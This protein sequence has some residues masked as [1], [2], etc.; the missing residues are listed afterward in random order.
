M[1]AVHSSRGSLLSLTCDVAGQSMYDHPKTPAFRLDRCGDRV[2]AERFD[3]GT[4]IDHDLRIIRLNGPN[5]GPSSRMSVR[6]KITGFLPYAYPHSQHVPLSGSTPS[7]LATTTSD[8]SMPATSDSKIWRPVALR[9]SVSC[10]RN[11]S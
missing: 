9:C 8:Q 6:N 10:G 4:W 2:A 1:A 7:M 5:G 11:T 3:V